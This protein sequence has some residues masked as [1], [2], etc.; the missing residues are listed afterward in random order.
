MTPGTLDAIEQVKINPSDR[1]EAVLLDWL[2]GEIAAIWKQLIDALQSA[3]V[4][5]IQ[6]ARKLELEYCS[7]GKE[8]ITYFLS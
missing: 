3:P 8:H 2:R 1:L 4:G 6:L 7:P 5:E